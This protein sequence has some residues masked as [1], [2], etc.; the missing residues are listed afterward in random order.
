M[1]SYRAFLPALLHFFTYSSYEIHAA[2]ARHAAR[3]LEP[4]KQNTF[5]VHSILLLFS[6]HHVNALF[7]ITKK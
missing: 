3:H 2:Q 4:G 6:L 1:P 5:I 7:E